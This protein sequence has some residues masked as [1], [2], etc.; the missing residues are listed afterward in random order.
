[1]KKIKGYSNLAKNGHAIVNINST[2]FNQVKKRI[3][4][5]QNK[6]KMI[7]DMKAELAELRK[8]ISDIKGDK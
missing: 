5:E 6:D 2:A 3:M 4:N 8:M 1:M 7:S